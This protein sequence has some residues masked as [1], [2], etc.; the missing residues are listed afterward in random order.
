MAKFYM[1]TVNMEWTILLCSIWTNDLI[2]RHLAYEIK[3]FR[4]Y[5]HVEVSFIDEY[6]VQLLITLIKTNSC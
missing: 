4:A 1:P 5:G 3:M 2:K 6:A